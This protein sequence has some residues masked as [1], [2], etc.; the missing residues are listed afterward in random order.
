MPIDEAALSK[1]RAEHGDLLQLETK[2]GDEFVFRA[3][4]PEEYDRFQQE[5][6]ETSTRISGSRIFLRTCCVHPGK[7]A[8]DDFLR[9]RPGAIWKLVNPLNEHCGAE[10]GAVR[11]K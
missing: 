10:E 3:A 11:K 2:W 8:V 6:A 5:H 7:E 4:T 9:R 1:L